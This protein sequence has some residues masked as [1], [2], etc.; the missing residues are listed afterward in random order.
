MGV[1]RERAAYCLDD[2]QKC[3]SGGDTRAYIV[4][5]K[6]GQRSVRGR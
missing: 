4:D 2:G 1:G 3:A 6:G 5:G